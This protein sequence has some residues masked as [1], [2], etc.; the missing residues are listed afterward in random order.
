MAKTQE[1]LNTLKNEYKTVTN[2]LKELNDEELGYVTGGGL[3]INPL[4]PKTIQVF[5]PNCGY[6]FE[7]AGGSVTIQLDDRFCPSCNK[8][9]KPGIRDKQQV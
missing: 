4:S 5:C 3:K 8:W 1:E 9:V 7:E 2:K 6:V